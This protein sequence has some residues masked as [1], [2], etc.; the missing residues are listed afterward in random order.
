MEIEYSISSEGVWQSG[1]DSMCG[2]DPLRGLCLFVK[3]ASHVLFMP[4]K[5]DVLV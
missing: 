3:I 4:G 5:T 1:A 2:R